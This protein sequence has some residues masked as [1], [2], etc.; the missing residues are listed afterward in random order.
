MFHDLNRAVIGRSAALLGAALGIAMTTLGCAGGAD[1]PL[2]HVDKDLYL[3]GATWP[4]GT[5]YVCYDG[6]DGNNQTLITQ[7][8]LLLANSWRRAAN[9]TFPG[10]S[11]SGQVQASW[12]QCNYATRAGGAF[13]TV[14]LHFCGGS[15]TSPNC[16]PGSYDGEFIHAGGFR[17]QSNFG[18]TAPIV[19][20]FGIG[21]PGITHVSLISDD[22]IPFQQRFRYEVIHEF[23][24]ALGFDH[25]QDR[26]DNFNTM[27]SPLFCSAS[28]TNTPG[29]TPETPLVDVQSIMSYC[30]VDPLTSSGFATML[31]DGD[32][33]GI[34]KPYVRRG[35]SHGFMIT[36]DTNSAL[37][38]NAFGGAAP[39]VVL[40]LHDQCTDTNP[41]CT[42]TYQRGMLVSDT[43]PTLAINAF[44]GAADG[45]VLKLV[46]I[47][48]QSAN[49]LSVTNPDCSGRCTVDNPDCTW[50][51]KGGEFLSDRDQTLA[52]NAVGG[53]RLGTTLGLAR[54][55]TKSNTDCTWT[56]PNV[57]FSNHRDS[58]LKLNALNGAAN[59]TPL[60]L[61]NTCDQSNPDCTFTF[62][63]GM[64]LSDRNHG[65]AVNA[66]LGARD[67]ASVELNNGCSAANPDCT[68]TWHLGELIS[69]NTAGG[70]FPMNAVGG[71]VHLASIK[72]AVACTASNPDCVF[73]GLYAKN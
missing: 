14:A 35:A 36:S 30:T 64:L 26:P 41:D 24:H 33:L 52:L 22:T 31:S 8:Q 71:A 38:V 13:S 55:C 56:M 37:A 58:T 57:M 72:L 19:G 15:S 2:E 63:Q 50:T 49:P 42:W 60:A 11:T 65:L 28:A 29:G 10:R 46:P 62:T 67:G 68:W 18:L 39:Y 48:M 45:T 61:Y 17:G 53:A 23:G 4:S 16:P 7:A 47:C 69:D 66:F 21:T 6:T 51:Y 43:D 9:I 73:W 27:G 12:D 25:E 34:R 3:I 59:G 70:T 40:K 20:L 44:G 5:V 54:A 1:E 32:T